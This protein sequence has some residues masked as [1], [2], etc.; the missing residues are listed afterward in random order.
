MGKSPR[1]FDLSKNISGEF[2]LRGTQVC[3]AVFQSTR[4]LEQDPVREQRGSSPITIVS[5][6][7]YDF[8]YE[9]HAIACSHISKFMS[10]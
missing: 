9:I 8:I 10:F 6:T 1:N 3:S 7:W 5:A 2:F 4:P